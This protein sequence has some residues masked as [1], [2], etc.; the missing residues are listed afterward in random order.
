MN[1]LINQR[2]LD[3]SRNGISRDLRNIVEVFDKKDG[4]EIEIIS[5]K[6]A[7]KF[8]LTLRLLK[9]LFIRRNLLETKPNSIYFFPQVDSYNLKNKVSTFVRLHDIFPITHP[10]WYRF[11]SVQLFRTNLK[12]LIKHNATFICNSRA[13][14]NAFLDKFPNAKT[15]LLYCNVKREVFPC[16]DCKVCTDEFHF[17]HKFYLTVG[18]IEP[19][20]NL[21]NL[22]S[23]WREINENL[24]I[25]GKMGWKTR[26]AKKVFRKLSNNITHLTNVCDYGVNFLTRNCQAYVSASYDEGFNFPAMDAAIEKKPL[27]ISD[28]K[29]HNELYGE[30]VTYINPYNLK[31]LQKKLMESRGK[32]PVINEEY[33]HQ[34]NFYDENL[35]Q[36]LL[37]DKND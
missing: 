10:F 19:R 34:I 25:V 1:I 7:T 15:E 33:I 28:V 3:Q 37:R 30:S 12:R 13:T 20:K 29:I 21:I 23:E 2:F 9:G 27:I 24:V 35:D 31:N 32:F 36:V 6:Y 26:H 16:N 18:T 8:P 5:E 17:N 22:V 4:V 14:Q 11:L